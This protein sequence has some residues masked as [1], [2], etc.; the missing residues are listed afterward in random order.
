[1]GSRG[2]HARRGDGRAVTTTTHRRQHRQVVC[3]CGLGALDAAHGNVT[4]RI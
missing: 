3:V 1:M 4:V 2:A